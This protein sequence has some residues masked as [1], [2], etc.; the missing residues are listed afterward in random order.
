MRIL[1]SRY[2][3]RDILFRVT[4]GRYS[5][6]DPKEID[7]LFLGIKLLHRYAYVSCETVLFEAGLINQR[8]TEITLVSNISKRFSLLG[9]R[10]RSRRMQDGKLYDA[11]GIIERGGVKMATPNRA[12]RDMTYFNPKKYYDRNK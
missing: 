4:R 2:V 5:I 11:T 7:P 3:K 10:Y 8:P 12:K 6:V 9:H 1:L